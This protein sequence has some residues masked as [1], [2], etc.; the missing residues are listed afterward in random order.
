[1]VEKKSI[2][3]VEGGANAGA[4][5]GKKS[6]LSEHKGKLALGVAATLGIM[7]FYNWRQKNLPKE[8]PEAYAQLKRFKESMKADQAQSQSAN[9]TKPPKAPAKTR[10]TR[11]SS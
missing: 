7:V 2:K 6:M 3:N 5:T 10:T 9:G 1:M 8:D 11:S 4:E